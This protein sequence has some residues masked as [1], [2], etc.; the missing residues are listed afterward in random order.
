[1]A[2]L[3]FRRT[4]IEMVGTSEHFWGLCEIG[5][6]NIKFLLMFAFSVVSVPAIHRGFTISFP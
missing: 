6:A 1:M 3:V 2:L 5:Y 4:Q